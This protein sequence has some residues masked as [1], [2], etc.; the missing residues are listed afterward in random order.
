MIFKEPS[1]EFVEIEDKDIIATS[2]RDC[3]YNETGCLDSF[4]GGGTTCIGGVPNDCNDG[5]TL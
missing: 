2:G 4:S 5:L 1:I 3:P